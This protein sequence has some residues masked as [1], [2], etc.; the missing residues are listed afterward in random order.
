MIPWVLF[1]AQ[2]GVNLLAASSQVAAAGEAAGSAYRQS[3]IGGEMERLQLERQARQSAED[4]QRALASALGSQ[5]A[6]MGAAG[7][8]GGRTAR[9][10]EARSRLRA[11]EAQQREDLATQTR[12]QASRYRQGAEE[13]RI[14]T[15]L[16]SRLQQSGL[17]LFGSLLGGAQQGMDLFDQS[18][19][20]GNVKGK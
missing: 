20:L 17:G 18:K 8:A 4:R 7:V 9:L 10:L 6:A 5:R 15:Q 13:R 19:A 12:L 14:N 16:R 2:Q 3:I 11:Q 1:A